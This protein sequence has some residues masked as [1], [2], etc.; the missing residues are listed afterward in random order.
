MKADRHIVNCIQPHPID[1]I[2][3]SS[4]IEKHIKIFQ[5]I[6]NEKDSRPISEI[7]EKNRKRVSHLD[8]FKG[9]FMVRNILIPFRFAITLVELATSFKLK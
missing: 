7:L 5:P 4:G 3:A 1:P 8:D 9:C 6:A 2:I